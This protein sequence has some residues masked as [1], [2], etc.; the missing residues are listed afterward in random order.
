MVRATAIGLAALV[1][2][3]VIA[4]GAG[5]AGAEPD[6]RTPMIVNGH[7]TD[8]GEF[9][10]MATLVDSHE[11]AEDGHF[12]G[13][14]LVRPK[15]ILTASHCVEGSAP[16]SFDVVVGRWDLRNR[17]GQ[18]IDVTRIA[19]KPG[20]VFRGYNI[21][22]DVAQVR[23]RDRATQ[24]PIELAGP[25]DD[26]LTAPG[27]PAIVIGYGTISFGSPE[28]SDILLQAD[29][30]ITPEDACKDTYPN[31]KFNT[32]ICAAGPGTDSCQ[33][34]SGGPLIVSDG[35]GGFLQAGVV[36]SG[37]GC[38]RRDAAGLYSRV[39]TQRGFILEPDPVFKP[40]NVERPFISGR[41]EVGRRLKCHQGD[42]RGVD[43]DFQTFWTLVRGGEATRALSD[44]KV[45]E[46]RDSLAG[47]NVSCVVTGTNDGGFSQERSK[48]GRV[49]SD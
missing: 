2:S 42:W 47:K 7:P 15:L 10:W 26:A 19:Q 22:N 29:I 46:L 17:D 6:Q 41:P 33:G 3:A 20:F 30:S 45:L 21:Y 28:Q 5:A 24:T 8:P 35:A 14:S 27:T 44:G 49:R 13:A 32:E 9:P 11:P 16:R 38:A 18:R 43:V 31:V 37:K 1:A 48:S 4:F 40:Y 25:E 34:D 12:C 23:L 39:S 36:S